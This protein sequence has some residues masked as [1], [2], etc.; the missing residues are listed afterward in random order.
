M[1]KNPYEVLGLQN[2]ASKEEV[3]EAY[4]RL[5]DKYRLDMHSEGAKGKEAAKKLNDV[6]NAYND[7][8][9]NYAE[10]GVE[11]K[12]EDFGASQSFEESEVKV[13]PEIIDKNGDYERIEELI[14]N[15]KFADA[16]QAL[17][18]IDNRNA[19][20]HYYQS[21]IYYK[22]GRMQESKA[23]LELACSMDPGN[24]RYKNSL[25]KL[26]AK[27]N[28]LDKKP[29]NDFDSGYNRSYNEYDNARAAEDG[30]CAACQTMLCLNCLCDCC[31]RG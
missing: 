8:L 28:D 12:Q 27:L 1:Y 4:L 30:C 13:E 15:K 17:D 25:D 23:Q 14:R 2:G 6:E 7:I 3:E 19:A 11:Y 21:V 16:Q 22:L 24:I 26:N 9:T 10:G 31:C 29:A 20:W 18:D 5:R